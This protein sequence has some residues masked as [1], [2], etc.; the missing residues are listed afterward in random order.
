MQ[1]PVEVGEGDLHLPAANEYVPT[2]FRIKEG[3]VEVR[4]RGGGGRED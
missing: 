4:G 3:E 1:K 2:D